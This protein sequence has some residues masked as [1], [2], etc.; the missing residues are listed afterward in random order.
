MKNL[1]KRATPEEQEERRIE[2]LWEDAG[3]W[4]GASPEEHARGLEEVLQVAEAQLR[5]SP[6]E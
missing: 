1:L 4:I 6:M 5:G 2:A 3:P